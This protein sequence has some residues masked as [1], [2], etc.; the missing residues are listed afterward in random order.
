MEQN[1]LLPAE[2]LIPQRLRMRLIEWVKNPTQ[3]GLQAETT[4]T[5]AWPLNRDGMVSSLICVEL[6]AQAIS[7][8]STWRRGEG[9]RP[10]VGLLVGIKEAE[11]SFSSIPVMT[12]LTIQID[13][14]YHVGG[15]AVFQG[16]VSSDL[17]LF[18]KTIIQVMEPE[19][20]VLSNV[21]T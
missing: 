11:F 3:N 8:L 10:R 9:A 5:E 7:A 14:L 2:P 20:E 21:K 15:Y 18:C 12:R 17:A 16:K 1:Q 6:V 4:V 13:E 19:E